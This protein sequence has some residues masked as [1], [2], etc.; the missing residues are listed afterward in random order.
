MADK[1]KKAH[2]IEMALAGATVSE[3][4]LAVNVGEKPSPR[5]SALLV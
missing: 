3:I 5:P 1:T 4:M 2:I